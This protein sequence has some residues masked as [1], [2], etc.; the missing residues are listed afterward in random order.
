L[1]EILMGELAEFEIDEH[2]AAQQAVVEDQ[3]HE[4]VVFLESESLLPRLEQ[5]SLA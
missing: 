4:E 5:E 1:A 3:V 2:V